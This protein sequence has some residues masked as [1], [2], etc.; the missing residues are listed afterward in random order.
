MFLCSLVLPDSFKWH[1]EI[2]KKER[3]ENSCLFGPKT[4]LWGQKRANQNSLQCRLRVLQFSPPSKTYY[5]SSICF[6]EIK[7][8]TNNVWNSGFFLLERFKKK[9]TPISA[10]GVCLFR[11]EY[12]N[13]KDIMVCMLCGLFLLIKQRCHF[14]LEC[15]DNHSLI[16]S[17]FSGN[18]FHSLFKQMIWRDWIC[19]FI[20]EILHIQ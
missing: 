9:K 7:V 10:R 6:K 19:Y 20:I 16:L 17:G 5:V 12:I 13:E 2:L 8:T 18:C 4:A 3:K 11:T 1:L 15:I 14:C